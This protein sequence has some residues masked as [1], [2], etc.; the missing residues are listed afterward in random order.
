MRWCRVCEFYKSD[1][2]RG[3]RYNHVCTKNNMI[4]SD[5]GYKIP[6]WCP[7]KGKKMTFLGKV[8]RFKCNKC[9]KIEDV[10]HGLPRG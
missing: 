7:L 6:K 5:G 3:S 9:G 10:S 8:L 2:I 1:F 4:L